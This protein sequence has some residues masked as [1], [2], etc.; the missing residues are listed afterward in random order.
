[1][2]DIGDYDR[3]TTRG[4]SSN[5]PVTSGSTDSS[6]TADDP[7]QFRPTLTASGVAIV[8]GAVATTVTLGASPQST[9]IAIAGLIVLVVGLV[10]GTRAAIDLGPLLIFLG[11]AIASLGR[12]PEWTVLGTIGVLVAWDLANAALRLGR[13]LGRNAS[14]ARL[15]WWYALSSVLVGIGAGAVAYAVFVL[16]TDSVPF[17]AFV[18]LVATAVVAIVA[19]G[20]G[21]GDS[22]APTEIP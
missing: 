6:A 16:G 3:S 9:V 21:R 20:T 4:E 19:L 18:V 11:V 12:P 15:E 14:T 1:M 22:T 8:A 2:S 7:G 13:Q 5:P 10:S 17:G